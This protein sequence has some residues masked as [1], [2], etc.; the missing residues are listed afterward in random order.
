MMFHKV[1]NFCSGIFFFEDDKNVETN[2]LLWNH[3]KNFRIAVLWQN[4]SITGQR[5]LSKHCTILLCDKTSRKGSI[6]VSDLISNT[7]NEIAL[8][9]NR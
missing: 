9:S 1:K 5:P 4:C 7:A 6:K 2:T 8:L 3:E